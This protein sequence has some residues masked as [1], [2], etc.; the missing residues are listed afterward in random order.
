M[1][2]GFHHICNALIRIQLVVKYFENKSN[3]RININKKY[4]QE[5]I[6]ELK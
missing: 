2:V 6:Y 3:K 4:K 1:R 5:T